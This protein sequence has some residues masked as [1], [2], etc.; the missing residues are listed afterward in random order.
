MKMSVMFGPKLRISVE[1]PNADRLEVQKLR[2]DKGSMTWNLSAYNKCP[3]M[4]MWSSGGGA[5]HGS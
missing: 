3:H 4:G 5:Y 2:P 1:V